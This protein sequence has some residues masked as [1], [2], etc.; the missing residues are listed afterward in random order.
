MRAYHIERTMTNNNGNHKNTKVEKREPT[1]GTSRAKG[2]SE[3]TGKETNDEETDDDLTM[4]N[5]LR[6][7]ATKEKVT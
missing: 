1:Q 4:E 2:H 6:K 3:Q 5:K 7:K